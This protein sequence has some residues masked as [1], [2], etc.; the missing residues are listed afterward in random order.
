[1]PDGESQ[2]DGQPNENRI[3]GIE[4]PEEREGEQS[5]ERRTP[6]V[7]RPPTYAIRERTENGEGQTLDGGA[8]YH[9]IQDHAPRKF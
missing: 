5:A 8:D 7:H 6:H 2:R 4:E 3:L 9:T 1:M